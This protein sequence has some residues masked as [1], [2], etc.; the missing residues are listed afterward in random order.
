V[1]IWLESAALRYSG[2][3]GQH[4]WIEEN[5]TGWTEW[6]CGDVSCD[7]R[8]VYGGLCDASDAGS[9]AGSERAV[10]GWCCAVLSDDYSGGQGYG[11][12][13][14]LRYRVVCE[15]T[16]LVRGWGRWSNGT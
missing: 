12:G 10:D 16:W 1:L 8:G 3:A 5:G 4:G 6:V 2:C 14:S 13:Q 15:S 9:D 11:W 7:S